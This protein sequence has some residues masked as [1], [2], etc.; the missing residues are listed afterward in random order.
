MIINNL[1]T[2]CCSFAFLFFIFGSTITAQQN[3]TIRFK[4]SKGLVFFQDGLKRDTISRNSGDLFYLLVPDSLKPMLIIATDNGRF[5]QTDNVSIYRLIPVTGHK[6][7]MF[8]V[9]DNAVQSEGNRL[10][11][12]EK[13]SYILKSFIN[14]L[15]AEPG[16]KIKVQI[17]DRS[18]GSVLLENRFVYN[19]EN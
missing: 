12:K 17:I 18:A 5:A 10:A 1:S 6:Y 14:G 15:S 3:A 2:R 19:S 4:K 16:N 13:K 8:Y 11:E 9:E 7:E